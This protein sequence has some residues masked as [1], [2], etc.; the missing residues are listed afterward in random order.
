M[1][2]N[3]NL[4]VKKKEN[5]EIKKYKLKK[6]KLHILQELNINKENHIKTEIKKDDKAIQDMENSNIN[7][8]R[9][10]NKEKE[11]KKNP[12]TIITN[13]E[14]KAKE[15][16]EHLIQ[17]G[18]EDL[19]EKSKK[20]YLLNRKVIERDEKEKEKKNNSLVNNPNEEMIKNEKLKECNDSNKIKSNNC[21]TI[22]DNILEFLPGDISKQEIKSMIY[23]ALGSSI[24]KDKLKYIKGKNLTDEQVNFIIDILYD[25]VNKKNKKREF[26][27]EILEGQRINIEFRDINKQNVRKIIKF[28]D[29]NPTDEEIEEVLNQMFSEN[30]KSKLFVIELS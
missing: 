6:G 17:I 20:K 3:D 21:L 14:G 26:N 1:N 22:S 8:V 27:D 2:Y 25:K 23:D 11:N 16:K 10:N 24:V 28:K 18:K 4:L 7:N 5:Q 19:E 29:Y 13:E 30:V 15:N 12:I 9:K